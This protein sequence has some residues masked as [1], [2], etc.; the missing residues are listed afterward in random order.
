MKN[1]LFATDFSKEAYCALYYA[2]RLFKNEECK[3]YISNFFG[4]KRDTSVY[5]IVNEEDYKL[6]PQLKAK[7]LEGCK[8]VMHNI[9]RDSGRENHQFEIFTSDQALVTALPA[10]VIKKNIDFV[11]MGTR[12]HS[13]VVDGFIGSN[14]SKL[15]EES[16]ACPL[17]VVPKERD[18][19]SP[20][21]LALATEFRKPFSSAILKPLIELAT[22]FESSISI[23]YVGEEEELNKKQIENRN[24][25][26]KLLKGI[27]THIIYLSS[28]EEISKTISDY[29][30][31]KG[32]NL[33]SMIY[34]KHEFF[35]KIFREPV[36][37]KIDHHLA[38][39][40][41]VL[42]EEK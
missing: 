6:I 30:K 38:F 13:G 4:D 25:L 27:D 18:F 41:L 42:P 19:T 20:Q 22:S 23:I 10:V 32:I 29:I 15:I 21:K 12:G 17:L 11:V 7:S 37:K 33:L 39:P 40:F 31:T 35:E 26:R 5:R 16:L 8:E 14:T 9:V 24:N 3:F 2:T 34:Y 28:D 36:V 1:I